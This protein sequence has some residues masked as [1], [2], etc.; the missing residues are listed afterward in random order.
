ML[1]VPLHSTVA[2]RQCVSGVDLDAGSRRGMDAEQTPRVVGGAD[3]ARR[4]RQSVA[5]ERLT[6]AADVDDARVIGIRDDREVALPFFGRMHS[7]DRPAFVRRRRVELR[8]ARSAIAGAKQT[9]ELP[10]IDDAGVDLS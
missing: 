10:V 4:A 1:S 7:D 9:R 3:G 6:I 2:R 5:L 8:P